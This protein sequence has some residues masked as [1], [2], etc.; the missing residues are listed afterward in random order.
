M[1]RIPDIHVPNSMNLSDCDDPISLHG[2]ATKGQRFHLFNV[3]CI[4]GQHFEDIHGSQVMFS[5]DS[6][7]PLTFP[8]VP[9]E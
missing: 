8:L 1:K 6:V 4:D 3:K 9:L 7:A 2:A 5:N